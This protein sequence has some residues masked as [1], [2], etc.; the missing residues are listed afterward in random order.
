MAIN[1]NLLV[2]SKDLLKG[3]IAW[4][5]GSPSAI[6]DSSVGGDNVI[7]ISNSASD[8]V[9]AISDSPQKIKVKP[10]ETYT[11]SAD[12]K[13]NHT[14]EIYFVH[15]LEGPNAAETSVGE[16]GKRSITYGT[17]YRISSTITIPEGIDT[18]Y[19]TYRV[20]NT[21]GVFP[22]ELYL[23]HPKLEK[24][25]IATDYRPAGVESPNLIRN[26][27]F[28]KGL[29]Y[30]NGGSSEFTK[31]INEDGSLQIKEI[32]SSTAVHMYTFLTQ[33]AALGKKYTLTAEVMNNTTEYTTG[34]FVLA[35]TN[36]TTVSSA[37]SISV[38][39]DG[40]YHTYTKT[41]EMS[42]SGVT[43]VRMQTTSTWFN[44]GQ[45]LN[46]KSI[47]LEEGT[48]QTE[49]TAAPEDVAI[50]IDRAII[51]STQHT[52]VDY[53]DNVGL[54]LNL[55]S[56]L[57]T[58]QQY[59]PENETFTPN[60]ATTNVVL[61]ASLY[62]NND[63]TNI[64]GDSAVQ[65][66]K[67]YEI[68]PYYGATPALI[69]GSPAYTVGSGTLTIKQNILSSQ[70]SADIL[71][72]IVYRD[73]VTSS[74]LIVKKTITFNRVVN[75]AVLT[76]A[77]VYLP[78]GNSLLNGSAQSYAD[79]GATGKNLIPNSNFSNGTSGIL[80]NNS[81][82]T[83][84]VVSDYLYGG[85]LK[86]TATA[87]NG[88]IN[89]SGSDFSTRRKTGATY[90]YS[91]IVKADSPITIYMGYQGSIISKSTAFNIGTT[92]T[93]IKVNG[94]LDTGDNTQLRFY[95]GTANV[96]FYVT[97]V[98]FESGPTATRWSMAP[99]DYPDIRPDTAQGKWILNTYDNGGGSGII[100]TYDKVKPALPIEKKLVPD[101]INLIKSYGS[102]YF[103]HLRTAIYSDKAQT[104]PI[105]YG[106]DD[107]NIVYVNGQSAYSQVGWAAVIPANITL[108][109]GW[110]TIGF[111]VSNGTGGDGIY[112]IKV[113]NTNLQPN[114]GNFTNIANWVS[115]GGSSVT[116]DTKTQ[117]KGKNTIKVSGS[118]SGTAYN[119]YIT[120]KPNTDYVYSVMMKSSIAIT[121]TGSTPIHMWVSA[122]QSA[123]HLEIV[124]SNDTS[125]AANEWKLLYVKFRTPNVATT[126]YMRPFIYGIG[127]AT[128]NIAYSKVEEGS[129]STPWTAAP[130]DNPAVNPNTFSQIFKMDASIATDYMNRITSIK[131]KAEL[132][133]GSIIDT[134]NVTYQW[135]KKDTSISTDQGGGIGWLK[136]I[137]T[138][139]EAGYNTNTLT[140][141]SSAINIFEVY[142]CIIKDT[143]TDSITY[144]TSFE[145]MVSVT[146]S[147]LPIEVRVEVDG[148]VILNGQGQKA[149]RAR[150]YQGGKEIDTEG[151]LYTYRWYRWLENATKD[152]SWNTTGYKAGKN[153][154]ITDADV[155]TKATFTVE[156]L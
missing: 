2:W 116:L 95:S 19:T 40:Q 54:A 34:L 32:S 133:R 92:W 20:R 75:G 65:S 48:Y 56:N 153:I 53:N 128:V 72:E 143:Q 91:A 134:T 15:K 76:K 101:G 42:A 28:Y 89:T 129:V 103:A 144:N 102:N 82:A 51:A 71:C 108:K 8:G 120:L 60:W 114:S 67:W 59:T 16:N 47:K 149:I 69:T 78:D 31:T 138:S 30:W 85:A 88:G 79:S 145:S 3:F 13:S 29:D 58:T 151:T 45:A 64:I 63:V 86:V 33:P 98:K 50:G 11:V 4:G 124:T 73:P 132:T 147:V 148:R 25:S 109:E 118:S 52:I 41:L 21:T 106:G 38:P 23:Y 5:A 137:S 66:I 36:G 7:M 136:L 121:G 131:A 125:I 46:Y 26:S 113:G 127:S 94:E 110:N 140:I 122:T 156:V 55:T 141:P 117:Y 22:T 87:T 77:K 61:T 154:V 83:A 14:G 142:K 12:F 126:Y 18:M 96:P 155:D 68:S 81:T 49:W 6:E 43:G 119:G 146:N 112:D 10:G 111:G 135:Y 97:R 39:A 70:S 17:W 1:N 84:S 27:H 80:S 123:D 90:S 62:R 107:A 93:E 74:D 99:E 139:P 35:D 44:P 24:G 115:N 105:V 9:V 100:P 57:N 152:T 130:A 150:L 104:I 37:G